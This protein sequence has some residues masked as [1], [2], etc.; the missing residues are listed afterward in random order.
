M[1]ER[2]FAI[3]ALSLIYQLFH[4]MPEMTG[5]AGQPTNAVFG[6]VRDLFH[7]RRDKK[8]DYWAVCFDTHAPT[9]RHE[10]F[11]EYKSHRP[12]QPDDLSSQIPLILRALEGFGIPALAQDGV[13]ADDLLASLAVA[14]AGRG[15][16][17]YLC[18]A[19][20]DLR[21]VVGEHVSML[22]L[23]R[24]RLIDAEYIQNDWG[25]SPTQAIDYQALVGDSVDFIPGVKGV[26]AKT[27]AELLQK[28]GTLEAVYE[29]LDEIGKPAVRK[30]LLAGRANAFLSKTLVTMKTDVPL[31]TDWTPWRPGV[32]NVPLLLELF[33]ECG[34][35]RF[36]DDLRALFPA[37]AQAAG[38]AAPAQEEWR[39]DYRAVTTPEELATFVAA[40]GK[41]TRVSVDLETTSTQPRLAEI[42]GYAFCWTEGEGWY[43][44]VQ[45]PEGE[46]ILDPAATLAALKPLLENPALAKVGQNLKYDAL[47]LRSHGVNLA[48]IAFDSMLA[49]YLLEPGERSH[50]L[51]EQSR[52][53][54]GHET[55]KIGDLFPQVGRSKPEIRMETV[56]IAKIAA[57]AA[58]DADVA[59]R[60]AERLGP[61][62]DEAKLRKLH[63]ELELPLMAVIADM[64]F[65]GI[66][67]DPAALQGLGEVFAKRIAEL[68]ADAH[69]Q[70][71]EAFNTDSP[72]Q[73]RVILFEKMKLP[74]LKRTKTGP[75]TDQEVLEELAEEHP[76]AATII[77]RRKLAKLK[78]TYID[79]L[80]DLVNPR[81]G[82]VHTSFHQTVAATGRLASSDP[83]L[84][85]IPIR[86]AEGQQIRKAFLPAEGHVLLAAD[87]SQIELRMLA[88]FSQDP[89]LLEAYA[90]DRD[91]HSLVAAEIAGVPLSEVTDE[92]RRAA[93]T[94]NFGVMYGLSPYGLA[95]RLKIGQDEAARF[96]DAYFAKYA[97]VD[98]FF[99][100]TLIAAVKNRKVTTIL[101]RHRK[102]DGIKRTDGRNRNLAERTAINTVIQGSAADLI[103]QAMLNVHRRLPEVPG[104]KL[105]LQIHDELVFETPLG[106]EKTLAALVTH[107]M[108]HALKLDGVPL[109]VE[110]GAG[111]NWLD[112]APLPS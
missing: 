95:R 77:E 12:A 26:G 60:L 44:P 79:N 69:A 30:N 70:A 16:K 96:I 8:P 50:G 49:S 73:L 80:P 17:A 19:D 51:D 101:G 62:L 53:L 31:P 37:A 7:L 111:P 4:G 35:H 78:G 82:R 89:A 90:H 66:R 10:I 67:V 112:L 52:R 33:A 64:E 9:F 2:L 63:D 97:A 99:S 13:E 59:W 108:E 20:K 48:G 56:P 87:Y 104:A 15:I 106:T 11:V 105:L 88:H 28:F 38:A 75:S 92:H 27:A 102:I 55:I 41:Q 94:V 36:G 74:V 93:K 76:L 110:V 85:N 29:R 34:F 42:V 107:E 98:A 21:Q 72:A 39:A 71:G 5:P 6:F 1:P 68:E 46:A 57:Y 58:E 43:L 23:R 40:L 86:T 24:N 47:V 14:A 61:K 83:N 45:G 18:T 103:K 25:V 54:L 84:Q 109:K 65:H 3:D 91:I 81:T 32:P 100:R 22:D